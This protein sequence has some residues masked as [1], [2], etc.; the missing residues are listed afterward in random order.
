MNTGRELQTW[1]GGLR[2]APFVIATILVF[3]IV[4]LGLGAGYGAKL[5]KAPLDSFKLE[6]PTA[7]P[8]IHHW[9]NA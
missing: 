3:S 4:A 9:S 5:A 1:T 6:Y 8:G 7:Y 2:L